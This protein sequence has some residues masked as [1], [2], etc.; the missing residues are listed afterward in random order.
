MVSWI[1]LLQS[2]SSAPEIPSRYDRLTAGTQQ[3][4]LSCTWGISCIEADNWFVA[5]WWSNTTWC[6]H[7]CVGLSVILACALSPS[8]L[9]AH[10]GSPSFMVQQGGPCRGNPAWVSGIFLCVIPWTNMGLQAKVLV[11]WLHLALREGSDLRRITTPQGKWTA[12]QAK[13]LAQVTVQ[14]L[15]EIPMRIWAHDI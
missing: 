15:W 13:F 14:P 10:D 9:C 2:P 8:M 5:G 7:G 6:W 3:Q 1:V 4:W 12:L 11:P